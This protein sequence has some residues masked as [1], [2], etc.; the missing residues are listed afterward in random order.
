MYGTSLFRPC[1]L[2]IRISLG[3]LGSI[4]VGATLVLPASPRFSFPEY[5]S[6]IQRYKVTYLNVAPPVVLLLRNL[7]SSKAGALRSVRGIASGG[8]PTPVSAVLDV[9]SRIGVPV[10]L[11][12]GSSESG[13]TS[14]AE[15]ANYNSDNILAMQEL[16]STGPPAANME[17]S[18]QPI[19]GC[20]S[21]DEI[22]NRRA[23]I[24]S[25]INSET[26]SGHSPQ[27]TLQNAFPGEICLRGPSIMLGYYGG[28]GSEEEKIGP[29]LD[30]QTTSPAIDSK[31]WYH[32][33]DEGLL[34]ESGRL[35]IVGRLK[36]LI[37][38]KGFQV[39][40]VELDSTFSKHKHVL[41]AAACG[42]VV[43]RG[44]EREEICAYIVPRDA[45]VLND[46]QSQLSLVK[47]L[48]GYISEHAAQYVKLC[49]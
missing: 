47:E 8:A 17:I 1:L 4:F 49:S 29:C 7:D 34:D 40:P 30:L 12:Y 35:W 9:N 32:T 26:P 3:V 19:E 14:H 31:G 27:H 10:H 25:H 2:G 16:G 6:L 22:A 39:S 23:Q 42:T 48:S 44:D 33:G 18:I 15:A 41:D 43:K 5:L 36:E 45:K 11:A 38:I 37:K 28:F 24:L 46:Q 21:P 13:F 20:V